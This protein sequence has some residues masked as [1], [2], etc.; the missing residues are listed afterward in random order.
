MLLNYCV[1]GGGGITGNPDVYNASNRRLANLKSKTIAQKKQVQS[2]VSTP[3]C[4]L[5][6]PLLL[7]SRN[8]IAN[9]SNRWDH[10]SLAFVSNC[11]KEAQPNS[12]NIQPI[13]E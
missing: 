11:F 7:S 2:I 3:T 6:S 4:K 12:G 10:H 5:I 9:T 13:P 8:K 1:R